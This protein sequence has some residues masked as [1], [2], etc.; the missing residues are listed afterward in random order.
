MK[1]PIMVLDTPNKNG[2]IYPREVMKRELRKYRKV[3]IKENRALI[4]S[5]QPESTTVNIQDVIGV[6]N[7]ATIRRNKVVV[8]VEFL[9]QIPNAA[10]IEAGIK[11]GKLFLRTSGVGSMIKQKD[12]TYKVSDDYE[13]IGCFVTDKPS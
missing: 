1:I 4:V 13:L 5:K 6:V 7:K 11:E 10:V 9:K 8:E 12:G 3:F 2:R